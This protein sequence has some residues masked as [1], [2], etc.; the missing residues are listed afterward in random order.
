MWETLDTRRHHKGQS[1]ISPSTYEQ[2]SHSTYVY[3]LTPQN[4]TQRSGSTKHHKTEL[5]IQDLLKIKRT[6]SNKCQQRCDEIERHIPLNPHTPISEGFSHFGKQFNS[7]SIC[8]IERTH[9][10]QQFYSQ[11]YTCPAKQRHI[12]TQKIIVQEGP[13]PDFHQCQKVERTQISFNW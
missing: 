9:M 5:N 11:V 12:S 2:V 3:A 4:R 8:S 1:K 10:T 6:A 13:Q 7:F